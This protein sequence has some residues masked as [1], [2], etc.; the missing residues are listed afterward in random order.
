MDAAKHVFCHL[1]FNL[2]I[3]NYLSGPLD[4]VAQHYQYHPSLQGYLWLLEGQETQNQAIPSVLLA[5]EVLGP[6][7]I[8]YHPAVGLQNHPKRNKLLI[9]PNSFPLFWFSEAM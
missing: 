1:F 3:Q 4:Q 9:R 6:Q 5:Q 2:N 7:G 8:L